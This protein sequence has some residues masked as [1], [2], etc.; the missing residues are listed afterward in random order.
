MTE[1]DAFICGSAAQQR[2]IE[3]YHAIA[4]DV[5]SYLPAGDLLRE[6][7]VRQLGWPEDYFE[8]EKEEL[9]GQVG[10]AGS[11]APDRLGYYYRE[12]LALSQ[13]WRCR[14]PLFVAKGMPIGEMHDDE[15]SGPEF[16][17]FSLSR[18]A[19]VLLPRRKP[20]LLPIALLNG[21]KTSSGGAI[22][23]HNLYELW[24]AQEEVRQNAHATLEDLMEILP[25]PDFPAG[26]AVAGPESIRAL[27]DKGSAELTVRADI[28]TE[29]E[30][31]RTRVAIISL[32]PGTLIR[33]ALTRISDLSRS[34]RLQL[35]HIDNRSAVNQV[36]IVIDAP[37]QTSPGRLK[38]VLFKEAGLEQRIPF[39]ILPEEEPADMPK[40]SSALISVLR[41]AI[42]HCGPAWQRKDGEELGRVPTLKEVMG[43]GGYKSPLSGLVDHRR[44]RIVSNGG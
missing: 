19:E 6:V 11:Y 34:G 9:I 2:L 23:P 8:L 10:P 3:A 27:Y 39:R 31:P 13:S 43:S 4:E 25:G 29:I 33:T 14:Y 20:P 12:V 32:P 40:G 16:V 5:D 35:F 41:Y 26:G 1:A 15:P 30:G 28:E 36:R 42:D 37:K 24:M 17:E 38:E 21:L 22:P 44:T 18:A 7:A